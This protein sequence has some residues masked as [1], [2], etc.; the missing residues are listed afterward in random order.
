MLVD[1][2]IERLDDVTGLTGRVEGAAEL[3]ALVKSGN[4]P[5]QTPA[6][7]VLPLGLR[8]GQWEVSTGIFRQAYE[9]TVSIVLVLESPSDATGA[10]ALPEI[11][12]LIWGIV[13]KIAG[14]APAEAV[15]VFRLVRGAL[16]SMSAGTLIYQLDFALQNQLRI[17][18]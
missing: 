9:E 2:I 12:D 17:T 15:S 3:S 5:Q 8:G 13:E 4:L 18:P 7:F 11:N 16:V 14:W 10:K 1:D 6:A